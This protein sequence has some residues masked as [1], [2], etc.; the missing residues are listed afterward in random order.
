MDPPSAP[1]ASSG[2]MPLQSS[3]AELPDLSPQP[4]H[5]S[6]TACWPASIL[7]SCR[8]HGWGT[9]LSRLKSI[10]SSAQAR[11]D[12]ERSP[13]FSAQPK[14]RPVAP[15]VRGTVR[16]QAHPDAAHSPTIICRRRGASPF[17]FSKA[18]PCRAFRTLLLRSSMLDID[19]P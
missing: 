16:S 15:K 12:A 17:G 1:I 10:F 4:S 6:L 13:M 11:V 14:N 9:Y 5:H 19:P 7:N 3:M 18:Q 8:Q 2:S